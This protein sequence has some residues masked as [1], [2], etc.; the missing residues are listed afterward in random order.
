MKEKLY[1]NELINAAMGERRM[2][3]E[4]LAE[5]SNTNKNTIS[6]VRDGRDVKVSTLHKV[7]APLNIKP[8]DLLDFTEQA[9]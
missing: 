2:T 4:E 5:L 6:K 8:S 1:R 9:V 7:A 3:V